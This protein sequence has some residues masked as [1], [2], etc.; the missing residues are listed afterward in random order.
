MKIYIDDTGN[1]ARNSPI[2][3]GNHFGFS[4]LIIN[5]INALELE[6][7]Y[8][9]FRRINGFPSVFKINE[10]S[11]PEHLKYIAKYKEWLHGWLSTL[12]TIDINEDGTKKIYLDAIFF[13]DIDDKKSKEEYDVIY[14]KRAEVI[15]EYFPEISKSFKSEQSTVYNAKLLSTI[16]VSLVGYKFVRENQNT[17]LEII[18]E[19]NP[20][21][22][23]FL[24]SLNKKSINPFY[25]GCRTQIENY[26]QNQQGIINTLSL[27]EEI[28]IT[29]AGKKEEDY[30]LLQLAHNIITLCNKEEKAR[31]KGEIIPYE[32]MFMSK[33][34]GFFLGDDGHISKIFQTAKV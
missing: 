9:N 2:N 10:N 24:D 15:K 22:E 21:Q 31:R 6:N 29:I 30:I 8:K 18:I 5:D 13:C 26:Y 14:K 28:K 3:R 17:G 19:E 32:D 11:G 16:I 23:S 20:Y 33:Y 1:V 12:N 25:A 27:P 34:K 4:G 7:A